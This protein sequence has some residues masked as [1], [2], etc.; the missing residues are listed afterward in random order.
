MRARMR[1]SSAS[2]SSIVSGWIEA[3]RGG[4]AVMT[5]MAAPSSFVGQGTLRCDAITVFAGE[6]RLHGTMVLR[7][8]RYDVSR[9]CASSQGSGCGYL[10]QVRPTVLFG[11][12]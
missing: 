11:G 7:I 8:P 3:G 1:S 10:I 6:I 9:L 4:W 12:S 5:D 2:G